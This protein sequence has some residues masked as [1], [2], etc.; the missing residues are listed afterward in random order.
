[1]VGLEGEPLAWDG[2]LAV[3]FDGADARLHRGR[4]CGPVRVT[5][6][7]PV[8]LTDGAGRLIAQPAR[9]GERGHAVV[10]CAHEAMEVRA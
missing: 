5:F 9:D 3:R 4:I 1:M 6:N 8:R 2:E 7:V 10:L